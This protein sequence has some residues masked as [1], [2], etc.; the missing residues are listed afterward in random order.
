M[1]ISKSV[2]T[3]RDLIKLIGASASIN[4]LP[5]FPYGAQPGHET[6]EAGSSGLFYKTAIASTMWDT[7]LYYEKGVFYLYYLTGSMSKW[8]GVG[9]ATSHDGVHW[10]EI[11]QVVSA[12]A[13][14]V[15]LGSGS[16][17]AVDNHSAEGKKYIINFSEWRGS[18]SEGRQTIFFAESQDL[19]HWKRLSRKYEFRQD[20]SWYEPNGRWDCIYALSRPGGGYYG[21]WTATPKDQKAGLGF[22]ESLDGVAWQT[23][24]PAAVSGFRYPP[25]AGAIH[26]WRTEFYAIVSGQDQDITFDKDAYIVR[27]LMTT[28]VGSSPSGPFHPAS[29]N[30]SLLVG[31]ASYFC[32][33]FS[34]PYGVLV[35]HHTWEIDEGQLQRVSTG[36]VYMAPLKRAVWDEAGTLRLMWWEGNDRIKRHPLHIEATEASEEKV[37]LFLNTLRSGKEVTLI[38]EGRMVLPDSTTAPP[39]GLYLQGSGDAGTVFFVRGNGIVECG[40]MCENGRQLESRGNVDRELTLQGLATFRLVRKG[41]LTEFYVNDVLMQCYCLPEQGTGRLG[42]IGSHENFKELTAWYV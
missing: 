36:H 15:W 18:E 8:S 30:P 2:A 17:W 27:G 22:G 13:D 26:R 40:L 25:E 1:V 32:R 4:I 37:P 11:G 9:M 6:K 38:L 5:H 12:A 34:T 19:F 39:V 14:A 23:L 16:V 21:Y 24:E 31:N 33:F 42:L 7:W 10:K 29:K 41:R 3:R 28:V 20:A 35:N